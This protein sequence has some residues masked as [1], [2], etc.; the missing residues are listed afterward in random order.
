MYK[1][2]T[3]EFD[4]ERERKEKLLSEKLRYRKKLILKIIRF[5]HHKLQRYF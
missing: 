2:I 5:P 1:T 4:R 3:R